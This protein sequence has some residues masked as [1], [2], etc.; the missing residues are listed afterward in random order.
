MKKIAIIF[1]SFLM[2]AVFYHL[3]SPGVLAQYC[4]CGNGVCQPACFEDSSSCPADCPPPTYSI[5]GTVFVDT[6]GNGVQN[7]G[8]SGYNSGGS[9]IIQLSTG[10]TSDTGFAGNYTFSGLSA[11]LYTTTLVVP[12]GYVATT[13]NPRSAVL[14]PDATIN[15][16]IRLTYTISGTVFDDFGS[17]NV[18]NNGNGVQDVGESGHSGVTVTAGANNAATNASGVYSIPGVVAGTYDVTVTAPAGYSLTTPN[19]VS[20][21]LPP[22]AANVNFGLLV[23]PP[24][25]AGGIS[26]DSSNVDPGESTTISATSCTDID[27]TPPPPFTWDP[28]T[29]GN[30]PPPTID[31]QTDTP[32][33][34][35]VTWTAPV[36]PAVLT[37]YTPAV[38][39]AG[40][41]G[42]TVYATN[43]TVP[44]TYTVTA[45]VRSVVDPSSCTSSS[46][47][48]YD[49]GAGSGANVN[50]NN[51]GSVNQNQT[52]NPATGQTTYTCLPSGNYQ[53]TLQVPSGYTVT[54]RT[55]SPGPSSNIGSNGISFAVT[56]QTATFCI[57]PIVPWYQTDKGDVR[58]LNLSN[59][60]PSGKYGS[61]D[62][63]FPG[64]YYSSNSTANLGSGT[65][66]VKNW[67]INNEYSYNSNTENRNGG[68]SYDFYKSKARQDGITITPLAVGIFDQAPITGSGIYEAPGDLTINLYTHV[69]GRR[70]VILVDGNVTINAPITISQNQGV[71]IVAAKGNMTVA[72]TVGVTYNTDYALGTLSTHSLDGYYSA[73]GSIVLDGDT[74]PDGT[75][76]DLRL[77]VGGVLIANSLKPFATTGTGTIQNKR[78]VCAN[79]TTYPSLYVA[80]R[81]DFITQLTDFYKTSY[82][83][84]QEVNP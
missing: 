39:V 12:S 36:C 46:G 76:A 35:T 43:I 33:S 79:S 65:A 83:K 71:L 16:G 28:D 61:A 74:C 78:S 72:K 32:T 42:N 73:Q 63:T 68:M 48:P 66:S 11:G 57:A 5:S 50:I 15:F 26:A 80:S 31:G 77:N 59:P 21:T 13:V 64:I 44:A 47:V 69:N 23:P 14:G 30:N 41:G 54:G 53:L 56:N 7:I 49:N 70:V 55:V 34:S 25:C 22:N 29:G 84:W 81:P 2:V 38:T 58:F 18:A 82:T 75:T 67:I 19:P 1:A 62:A 52:T 4:I 45:N 37:V 24:V 8:E 51:G 10:P 6:N 20:K 17:G 9:R 60:V 3:F 27:P 40:P